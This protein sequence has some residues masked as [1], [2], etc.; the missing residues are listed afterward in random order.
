V[1]GMAGTVL[2]RDQW[3]DWNDLKW[4]TLYISIDLDAQTS[5]AANPDQK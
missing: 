3:Y 4:S 5:Q 1:N 2:D